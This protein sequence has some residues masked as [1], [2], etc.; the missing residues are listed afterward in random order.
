MTAAATRTDTHQVV[1]IGS[2]FAGLGA[3]IKLR[4]AGVRDVVILERGEH[5]G[6][7]WRDNHY[8]GAACDIPAH[9]YSFSFAPKADWSTHYPRQPEIRAYLEQLTDDHGLRELIRFGTTVTSA[10]FDEDA[11]IW[12]VSDSSGRSWQASAVI[13]AS[14]WLS[15]P[16]YPPITGRERFGGAQFH[17]VDWD[18]DVELA[19]K[20]VGVVGTGASAVQFVPHLAD[21]AA[22]LTVFQ[23]SAPWIMPR[24][25]RHYSRLEK[26]L[27]RNVPGLRALYRALIYWQKELRFVGFRK[28]SL[29]MR[30][31]AIIARWNLRRH[32]DDP[33]KRAKLTPDYEMG[34]KRILIHNDFYRAVAHD[35]VAIETTAIEAITP[36]GVRLSD[37]REVG[38][39][40]LVWGT[41]FAV[42]EPLSELE[43]IGLGGRSLADEWAP[44]PYAHRGT[45]V[46]GFPNL[47]L[48]TGPNT[49]L[50]HN[51]M[52]H[53]M[54]SQY[55][56]IVA[57]I[58]HVLEGG[59]AYLHP[60]RDA[61]EAQ[62]RELE[63]RHSSLVWS[64][65][66]QSWYL[67]E[68][69][70]NASLWP[71]FTFE[72]RRRMADL[73][74]AE[75][76]VAARSS[77]E[78]ATADRGNQSATELAAAGET[79]PRSDMRSAR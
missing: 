74:L 38:L 60:R 44:H 76:H 61:T 16:S 4:E 30:L 37:G 24:A 46:P 32:V 45:T 66:C 20:R 67:T 56:Y 72:Y 63:L 73:D 10:V 42:R 5:I 15:D 3:A 49:G 31:A 11:A 19:G 35:H 75:F 39:D 48:M 59:V 26:W 50:G 2:G 69:G 9:L 47:F 78:P 27:F 13:N 70:Y 58:R 18:H 7:T 55:P 33:E 34:C 51:S 25:D 65:G 54:E 57:A 40:V 12:T 8:P 17:S 14:G 36:D 77:E 41:G 79:S 52:V 29:G 43:I 6:G 22:E 68:D 1:I 28:D 71:G 21:R 23:R 62:Q 64:S 53:I